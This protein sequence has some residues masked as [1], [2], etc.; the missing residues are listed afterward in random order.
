M[1]LIVRNHEEWERIRAAGQR[2]F[3]LRY[4]VIGRGLPMALLCALAIEISLGNPLPDALWS[5][6]FLGRL[7]LAFVFFGLGGAFTTLMTW[8]LYERRFDTTS[9]NP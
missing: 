4:G 9:G 6:S 2:R 8:R 5:A 3:L 7:A 1:A